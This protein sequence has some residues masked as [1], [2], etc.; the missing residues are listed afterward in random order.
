MNPDPVL[1][2]VIF[3][4]LSSWSF[5]IEERP[6][7]FS[8]RL[9]GAGAAIRLL[10]EN[11]PKGADPLGPD[12]PII[13]TVGT[14]TAL[15][16]LASKC[17]AMFKSPLTGNLGESHAGGRTAVAIRSAG[18]GAVVITGKASHPVYLSITKD[19]V[20]FRD[21][22]ALWGT[23]R[24]DTAARIIRSKD[25]TPGTRTI[26][27]IGRAG[28]NL[29]RYANVTSETYRHFG[30]MGLG[31]VFGS[32]KLKAVLISGDDLIHVSDRKKYR[33]LYDQLFDQVTKSPLMQKYHE[34]GTPVNVKSLSAMGSLPVKNLTEQRLTG[35][36]NLSG[37]EFARLF[38]SRRVA[39]SHC[40]VS[41]IH[42]GQIRI[43]YPNDPY[44]YKTIPVSYDYELIYAL[45]FMLGVSN[46]TDVLTLIDVIEHTGLDAM[47]A[48]VCAAWATEAMAHKIITEHETGGIRLSFGDTNQYLAF[49]EALTRQQGKFYK[50][51]GMGAEYAATKYG[52]TEYAL[53]F[54]KNE[55]PGY[56]TGPATYIGYI[57]GARHSHLDNAGYSIDQ[58]PD[59]KFPKD[60]EGIADELYH[61][62]AY[63][64]ILS[65]LVVC[66]FARGLYTPEII[67]EVLS[68]CGIT[69]SLKELD[70]LGRSILREKYLFKIR[71]GFSLE[72][73]SVP[74]PK[75]ILE[76]PSGRGLIEAESIR[77]GIER[78]KVLL[79]N[80]KL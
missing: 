74:I 50:D 39:C 59:E 11:C 44:F 57:C 3:I 22:R 42:I 41:C 38:L 68:V 30:R 8:T 34:I 49:F 35:G 45:G 66:F 12:N 43:P 75:R 53:A 70:G 26:L 1:S 67:Q 7:L 73:E 65:S 13:L 14:A 54:G 40:P 19:G 37:E 16:P 72:P 6:D 71:E 5:H 78:Y 47:S 2:K 20:A 15:F 56:H 33:E 62:E 63:R 55:M 10:D 69:M 36:E 52:G 32:K 58:K 18:Y 77:R 60:P 23:G 24:S 25:G 17:V 29:V 31:A 51:L 28:E 46:P 4:D 48:G 61:E 27:R 80:D 21:A 76:L 9:G 64:Q 79:E